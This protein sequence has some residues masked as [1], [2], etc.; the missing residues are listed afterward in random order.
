MSTTKRGMAK[1]TKR[2]N[3]SDSY[4]RGSFLS[5]Y[6]EVK[7]SDGDTVALWDPLNNSVMF[8]PNEPPELTR[9]SRVVFSKYPIPVGEVFQVYVKL[10]ERHPFESEA[11]NVPRTRPR[12]L[13]HYANYDN[14]VSVITAVK[15]VK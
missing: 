1:K 8:S 12:S 6:D 2:S 15:N 11:F 10:R 3:S 14:L 5:L 9:R 4:R 7:L 13:G